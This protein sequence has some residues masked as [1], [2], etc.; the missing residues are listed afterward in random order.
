MA[1][2]STEGLLK[3]IQS[4]E[5]EQVYIHITNKAIEWA[6]AGLVDEAN[7]FLENLWANNLPHSG[8]LWLPDQGLQVM[9][10]I[11]GMR[12]ANIPFDFT[13]TE[14]IEKEN[15]S[16][17]FFPSWNETYTS[18]FIHK[19]IQELTGHEAF[20]KA[21]IAAYQKSETM[22]VILEAIEKYIQSGQA[23]GYSY[24]E[25]TG[26]ASLLAARNNLTEEA[27]KFIILW[28]KGYLENWANYMVCYL[29]RDRAT[30]KLLST[31]ILAPIF[32]LSRQACIKEQS[33]IIAALAERLSKGRRL[34]Y[35]NLSWQQ[36]L[37]K[38]SEIA[39][40]QTTFDFSQ[41]AIETKWLGQPPTTVTDIEVAEKRL[42]LQLPQDYKDFLKT[43]NGF[44]PFSLVNV[45]LS[46]VDKAD[47][48]VNVDEDLVSAWTGGM[49]E[50]SFN[51]KF[52]K[53][54]IIGG[55]E[56][57]QMLLLIPPESGEWECWFFANWVPGERRYPGFRYYMEELLQRLEDGH[58]K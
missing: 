38:I 47:M 28:G 26:C 35:G 43:S 55:H 58:Y 11:S 39:I 56:E 30:A 9:W 16:R 4:G 17:F 54:I 21:I 6:V 49:F 34:A 36:L 53:S 37:K 33:E 2:Q 41:Q 57:E 22:P 32:G 20:T 52:R 18:K 19:P 23:A 45:T 12:P 15:W 44:N 5:L 42:G 7:I 29:L 50:E 8:H 27:K 13:S 31:G 14:E 51:N 25:A 3:E 48:L 24:F 1:R 46:S 10:E 40:E